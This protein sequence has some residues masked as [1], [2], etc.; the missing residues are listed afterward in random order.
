MKEAL[1][2]T[3]V[4]T[5]WIAGMELRKLSGAAR[6]DLWKTTPVADAETITLKFSQDQS[7]TRFPQPGCNARGLRVGPWRKCLSE[8]DPLSGISVRNSP[9][10]VPLRHSCYARTSAIKSSY[11]LVVLLAG[12]T[13]WLD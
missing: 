4:G 5:L 1:I 12:A 2:R 6:L 3:N 8:P 13:R 10:E 9:T 11:S 7:L